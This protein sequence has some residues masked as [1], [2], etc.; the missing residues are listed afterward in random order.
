MGTKKVYVLFL[1]VI[2]LSLTAIPA[3]AADMPPELSEYVA[4]LALG[5]LYVPYYEAAKPEGQGEESKPP[6]VLYQPTPPSEGSADTEEASS[7][8]L[9]DGMVAV[10]AVNLSRY[11]IGDTPPLLMVNET[12]YTADIATASQSVTGKGGAVLILHTHGTEAYLPDGTEHYSE[13]EDF[14]SRNEAE[15]VVAVGEAFAEVLRKAGIEVFHDTT[16]YDAADFENAYAA[17][18][19]GAKA[20]LS[21]H[22]QIRY[23]LDIH[24]D[25]VAREGINCK[26]LCQ[27]TGEPTAQVMLVIGTNEAGAN[28]PGW[29]TN[30]GLAASYQRELNTYPTLARPVYLRKA[31]YNQQLSAG[32]MLLEIGSAA[33]TVTEAKNAA[34]LAAEC[35]VTLYKQKAS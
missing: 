15:T 20:W 18:R 32:A 24:R 23:I 7:L 33:N 25:A 12:G 26:T 6:E 2:A 3:A 35:F 30:L 14:R 31:S 28:H 1:L 9:P 22:P 4:R 11:D 34:A 13:D 8:P 5:K 21:K 29:K 16:M 27:G 17:S 19:A 10:Q